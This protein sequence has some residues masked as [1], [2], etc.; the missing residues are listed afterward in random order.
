MLS[1]APAF[2]TPADTNSP[3]GGSP[4]TITVT[5]GTLSATNYDFTFVTGQLTI[6]QAVLTVK[7]DDQTMQSGATVPPL[8]ASYLGFVNGEDTNALSGIPALS[9]TVTSA[10]PPGV[11]PITTALGTLSAANYSFAFQ[12]GQFTVTAPPAQASPAVG[13][14]RPTLAT[15]PPARLTGIQ[16]LSTGVRITFTGA[17]A[18]TYQIQR[19][20]ALQFKGTA[21]TNI[22][23]ATTDST[24]QGQFTDTNPPRGQGY[25]RTVSQ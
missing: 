2:S 20:A 23:S 10:T 11:Y 16:V 19:A 21:W 14:L 6:T 12:D 25:Y 18:A 3:V 5:N 13:M 1:G 15:V 22:G 4:Y 7:A 9:T 24:G 8:T 17:A